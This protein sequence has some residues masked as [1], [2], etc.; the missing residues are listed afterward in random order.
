MKR[1]GNWCSRCLVGWRLHCRTPCARLGTHSM[2][3]TFYDILL[4]M[5]V[6]MYCG[7]FREGNLF[8][9]V[10]LFAAVFV[11]N[12]EVFRFAVFSNFPLSSSRSLLWLGQRVKDSISQSLFGMRH[13]LFFLPTSLD[14]HIRG[15]RLH[16]WA[17]S[18]RKKTRFLRE[19]SRFW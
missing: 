3:T 12:Y 16:L 10:S 2:C 14:Q 8:S 15:K 18:G 17:T 1:L 19:R 9:E 7:G 11:V 4:C 6:C 5:N 13:A